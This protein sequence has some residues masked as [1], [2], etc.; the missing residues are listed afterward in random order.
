MQIIGLIFICD[1]PKLQNPRKISNIEKE[2]L[3]ETDIEY[4]F[5]DS[6]E[7]S[8]DTLLD[9]IKNAEF[10]P[11]IV[12]KSWT[13]YCLAVTLFCC[14][15]YGN[16][17]YNLYKTFANHFID[18]DMFMAG[19]FSAGT[20]ANAIARIGDKLMY[21]IWLI[22]MF[23]CIAANQ[24]LFI[25]A[26]V[27]CFGTKHKSMNYGCLIFSTTISGILLSAICQTMLSKIG[28]TWMFTIAGIFAIIGN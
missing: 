28:Y 22:F 19:V 9:A 27:K 11:K 8:D 7:D 23:I 10:G 6:S 12:L 16:L 25:T 17:Y 18:D 20:I 24:S 15:F 21:S 13:F 5:S 14:S 26:V 4:Y 3:T 1:P 2:V